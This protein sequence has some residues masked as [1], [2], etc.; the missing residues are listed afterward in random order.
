MEHFL[1][2]R[3]ISMGPESAMVFHKCVYIY[4]RLADQ[5]GLWDA[6]SIVKER[7]CSDEGFMDFQPW[8]IA[9]GKE[10]YMAEIGRAHV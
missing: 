3:L 7:G 10:T 6:A 5:Y 4:S 1:T 2:D 8:L 9:Q